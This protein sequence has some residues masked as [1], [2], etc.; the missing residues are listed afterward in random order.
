MSEEH[1]KKTLSL[2]LALT[3]TACDASCDFSVAQTPT[4]S[5]PSPWETITDPTQGTW[6]QR[7]RVPHGWLYREIVQW[8]YGGPNTSVALAFVRDEDDLEKR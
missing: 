8:P 6:T 5:V 1:V 3:L 4:S 2:L 7:M